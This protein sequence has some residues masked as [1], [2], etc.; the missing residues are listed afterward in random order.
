MLPNLSLPTFRGEKKN[1][2]QMRKKDT[3]TFPMKNK[4][5]IFSQ[6]QKDCLQH[7]EAQEAL[8][9]PDAVQHSF[10]YYQSFLSSEPKMKKIHGSSQSSRINKRSITMCLLTLALLVLFDSFQGSYQTGRNGR[11]HGFEGG[12]LHYT[13]RLV[14][15]AQ[16]DS[17]HFLK[18][19]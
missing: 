12:K 14:E 9:F 1:P 3:L 19:G 13:Q 18:I 16:S 11:V 6:N 10:Q 17:T 15:T 5:V 8:L 4:H 7:V 2:N